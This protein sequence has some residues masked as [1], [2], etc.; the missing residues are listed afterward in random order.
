M[1][2]KQQRWI[3]MLV[4]CTFIWLMQVSTMPVAAAGTTAQVSSAGTESAPG[5]IEE[6]APRAHKAKGKSP[7]PFILIGIG[8]LAL[9]ISVVLV[10]KALNNYNLVGDWDFQLYS[11][12]YPGDNPSWSMTFY[13]DKK[14]GTF[15]DSDGFEGTY[16]VDGKNI[17][18]IAY[19]DIS[20]SFTGKF[21]GKD[22]ISGNYTWAY[23]G[24]VGT[25]T[26]S[27]FGSTYAMPK[28]PSQFKEKKD[29]EIRSR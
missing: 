21:D 4:V 3:A 28:S 14:S 9:T 1:I 26:G 6:D 24:E 7:L 17:T 12:T 18:R 16:S 19:D 2:K 29:R 15:V 23:Y 13:G 11:T 5:F 20:L 27:R 10:L 22:A 25:W 8:V